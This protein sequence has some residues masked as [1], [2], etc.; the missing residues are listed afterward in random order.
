V[1]RYVTLGPQKDFYLPEPYLAFGGRKN[2]LTILLAYA[3]QP[4]YIR[5]L[6][7]APYEEFS[8]RRTRIEFEW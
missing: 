1:G 8:A 3:D 5:T 2:I 4:N 7:V 6:R